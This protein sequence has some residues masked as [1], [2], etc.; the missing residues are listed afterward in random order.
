MKYLFI[1]YTFLFLPTIVIGQQ[2]TLQISYIEEFG[3]NDSGGFTNWKTDL[4]ILNSKYSLYRID[5]KSANQK[6]IDATDFGE[7]MGFI[8]S[9]S[10]YNYY[11]KDNTFYA[12]LKTVLS[13][14][15]API[16]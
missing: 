7:N 3:S 9:N 6:R 1:I 13:W 12:V 15:C 11:Y 2:N 5:I 4:T 14:L 8:P 10:T 16:M